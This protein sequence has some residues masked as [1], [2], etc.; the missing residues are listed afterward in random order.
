MV[1]LNRYP[2]VDGYDSH[3]RAFILRDCR[4]PSE[5]MNALATQQRSA[6]DP[7]ELLPVS[8]QTAESLYL[9]GWSTMP[10]ISL[11]GPRSS[12]SELGESS[13]ETC[14]IMGALGHQVE[15]RLRE[16]G[17][18]AGEGDLDLAALDALLDHPIEAARTLSLAG[19]TFGTDWLIGL[20]GVVGGSVLRLLGGGCVT[21]RRDVRRELALALAGPWGRIHPI[22]RIHKRLSQGPSWSLYAYGVGL[23]LIQLRDGEVL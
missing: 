1:V 16:V 22:Q 7:R 9:A 10:P 21:D 8:V 4:G 11:E 12:A 5:A 6:A 23:G 15:L 18:N 17:I 3:G 19:D 13:E 14:R 2:L 20:A